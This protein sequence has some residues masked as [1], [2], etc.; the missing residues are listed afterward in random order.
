MGKKEKILLL[1]FGLAAA[2]SLF[3]SLRNFYFQHTVLVPAAGGNYVEGLLGQPTYLNPLLA[4]EENDL[5]ITRLIF[6]GLYKYDSQGNIVPDLAEAM[7]VISP[8]QKSYTIELKKNATWHNEKPLTADDVVFTIQI[9]KD[10]AYKSPLRNLWLSTSVE[11]IGDFTVKFSTKD[12]SGPFIHNLTL[13]ILPK[14]LWSKVEPQNFVL[15]KLNLEAVGTGPYA[16][17][18]IKKI[19]SGKI[20]EIVLDSFSDYH[21]GKAKINQLVI[22]FY[23][24]EDD[25]LNALHSREIDGF[26][27]LS[28]GSSLYL[29]KNQED[30]QVFHIPT[31]QY[32]VAFFNQNNK[33]LAEQPV[34]QALA[35]A[36]DRKAIIEQVFNNNALLP[37]SPLA[38]DA[39]QE[40]FIA[41]PEEAKKILDNAGWKIDPQTNL[42][43]KRN[44]T[45]ELTI[46]TN[47]FLLN[48]K[49]AEIVANQWRGLNAKIN[50]NIVPTQQLTDTVIRPRNFDVLLFPQKFGADPDP[51]PFWHSSQDKDPGLNL[52]GFNNAEADRLI[53]EAR[54]TTNQELRRQ[55]YVEFE[56]L[57]AEKVPA[58][59]LDETIYIY[60]VSRDVSNVNFGRLYDSSQRFDEIQN[61]YVAEKREWK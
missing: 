23:D 58:I 18:E 29:E 7:P 21:L 3:L 48:S 60:A 31:P 9:L 35:A 15:S 41:N 28:L 32:Q 55:K 27:F 20:G 49:A 12:V 26:G 52:T 16:I 44:V 53:T 30:Y 14:S 54:T 24:H 19:S 56:K 34:R 47:D 8:D 6:S 36:L 4:H 11:K 61:W 10:P 17:K 40:S 45:L 38:P 13:P 2:L 1:A 51:F 25:I 39:E 43:T 57:I 5:T 22:K 33:I 42:R 59:F 37:N 46:T 50:L